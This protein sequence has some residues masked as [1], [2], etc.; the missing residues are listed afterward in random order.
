MS[1][2]FTVE[3]KFS[4]C[5][6]CGHIFGF[7]IHLHRVTECPMCAYKVRADL[8]REINDLDIK[9]SWLMGA[10]TRMRDRIKALK[11]ANKLKVTNG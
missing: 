9:N 5:G 4:T 3:M 11:A 7:P 2:T 10:S 8:Q 6:D 1:V